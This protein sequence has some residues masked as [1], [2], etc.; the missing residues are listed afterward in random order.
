MGR[1]LQLP[2]CSPFSYS[3]E[4]GARANAERILPLELLVRQIQHL[5][6]RW[7]TFAIRA[8]TCTSVCP[9]RLCQLYGLSASNGR[10][11]RP[12]YHVKYQYLSRGAFKNKEIC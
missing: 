2:F 12:A 9:I 3:L 1:N 10:V 5:L 4:R 11:G 8:D 6:H 7:E